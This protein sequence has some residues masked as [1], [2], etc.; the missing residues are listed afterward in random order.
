MTNETYLPHVHPALADVALINA[1]ECA[2]AAGIKQTLWRKLVREGAAPPP[3]IVGNRKTLWRLRDVHSF[4][5]IWPQQS[6]NATGRAVVMKRA[7]KA[8]AA[9]KCK[10]GE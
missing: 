6:D 10:Q 9:R 8:V 5:T 7:A 3:V 1:Q 2:A 4:L